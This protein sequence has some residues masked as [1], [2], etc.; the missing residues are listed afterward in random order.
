M[1]ILNTNRKVNL[2]IGIFHEKQSH[3]V[4]DDYQFN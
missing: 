4:S 1:F 3:S 2:L